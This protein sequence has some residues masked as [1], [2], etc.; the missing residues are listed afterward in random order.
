MLPRAIRTF[1]FV[2]FTGLALI[3]GGGAGSGIALAQAPPPLPDEVARLARLLAGS[4][5][6]RDEEEAESTPPGIPGNEGHAS[7]GLR[8]AI[9]ELERLEAA[10]D[11]KTASRLG[12]ALR[13]VREARQ[14]YFRGSPDL[15][16]LAESAE[17]ISRAQRALRAAS[18]T[19]SGPAGGDLSATEARLT[20]WRSAWLRTC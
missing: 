14:I 10:A 20:A 13:A 15:A 1:V 2:L 17:A 18:A 6:P 7:V 3:A 12:E 11:R 8:I 5:V 9:S 19:T 16:H 4:D